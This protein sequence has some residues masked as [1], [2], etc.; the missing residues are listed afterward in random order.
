MNMNYNN[1]ELKLSIKNTYMS[2]S[3]FLNCIFFIFLLYNKE[4]TYIYSYKDFG[5]F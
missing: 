1:N 3:K 5:A 4:Y 2:T